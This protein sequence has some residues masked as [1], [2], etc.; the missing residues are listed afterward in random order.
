MVYIDD[1]SVNSYA[2][3]FYHPTQFNSF[4]T[5]SNTMRII[6]P[7]SD[8]EMYRH[9][10]TAPNG[11]TWLNNKA[12]LILKNKFNDKNSIDKSVRVLPNRTFQNNPYYQVIKEKDTNSLYYYLFVFVVVA[13]FF[14]FFLFNFFFFF[15]IILFYSFF[16]N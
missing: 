13:F 4:H 15:F 12:N 11:D 3:L 10:M 14:I 5:P 1:L 7:M 2:E 8:E 9:P 16:F 6:P